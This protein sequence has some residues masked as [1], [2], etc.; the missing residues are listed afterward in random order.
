[1]CFKTLFVFYSST[2]I[3]LKAYFSA[4]KYEDYVAKECRDFIVPDDSEDESQ[5]YT[6]EEKTMLEYISWGDLAIL[7]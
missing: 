7:G 4:M 6:D 1:M 2:D 5:M 3:S